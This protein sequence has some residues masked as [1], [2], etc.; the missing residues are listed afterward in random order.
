MQSKTKVCAP[1]NLRTDS[2]AYAGVEIHKYNV[3]KGLELRYFQMLSSKF[4][5]SN[6]RKGYPVCSVSLKC[7]VSSPVK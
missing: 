3:T 6:Y 2:Y 1:L 7:A 4:S 5:K